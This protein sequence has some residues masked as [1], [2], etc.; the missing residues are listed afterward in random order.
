[1]IYIHV[2]F[3]RFIEFCNESQTNYDPKQILLGTIIAANKI[4]SKPMVEMKKQPNNTAGC[5]Q[6]VRDESIKWL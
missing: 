3:Q 4:P 1:M 2:T 6:F 5:S